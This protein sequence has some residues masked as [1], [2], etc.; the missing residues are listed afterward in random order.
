MQSNGVQECETIGLSPTPTKRRANRRAACVQIGTRL[1]LS[2]MTWI[3][4]MKCAT[5]SNGRLPIVGDFPKEL[6][7]LP[8][9]LLVEAMKIHQRVFPLYKDGALSETFLAVTN[10][11]YATKE[12]VAS[13]IADGNKRVL[14]ARFYDAKVLLCGRQKENTFEHGVK[15]ADMMWIRGGSVADKVQR[16]ESVAREWSHIFGANEELRSCKPS[17]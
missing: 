15:L 12:E 16:I 11:P 10:Q 17:V 8:S 2:S 7:F 4:W 13:I 5:L 9:K 6:L 1:V 14:T 3:W